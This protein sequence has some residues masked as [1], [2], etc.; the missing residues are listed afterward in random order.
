V[1]ARDKHYLTLQ[2]SQY[3][4]TKY[5]S[6]F[7]SFFEEIMTRAYSGFEKI[8]SGGGDGGNDGW[9]K[10]RGRYYQVYAP[11]TPSTKDSDAAKKLKADFNK[12]Q[13][14]WAHIAEVKEY[15]FVFN[16]RYQGA[17]KPAMAIAELEAEYPDVE[18]KLILASDLKET[19]FGLEDADMLGL[20][21]SIDQRDAVGVAYSYLEIAR[22]ELDREGPE[23]AK[24]ILEMGKDTIIALKDEDL[25]L[26]FEIL[27][28][29]CFQKMEQIDEAERGFE[30]LAKRVPADPRPLLYLSELNLNMLE[31]EDNSSNLEKARSIDADYWLLRLEELVRDIHLGVKPNAEGFDEDELPDESR[32]RSQFYRIYAL[33]CLL[34]ENE[35][36]ADVFIE[37]AIHSNG[38][39]LANFVVKL[40]I[41]ERRLT[42][43]SND[44]EM[45]AR[46]QSLLSDIEKVEE[47]FLAYGGICARYRA[48]LHHKKLTALRT[49]ENAPMFV[50][51][52]KETFDLLLSCSLDRQLEP[53][54]VDLLRSVGLPSDELVR[55]TDYLL[56]ERTVKS[57]ELLN[58]VLAQ[59]N[60]HDSLYT[61]GRE[62]FGEVG[63]ARY[64]ELIDA[65]ETKNHSRVLEI[66]ADDARLALTIAST[67][68]TDASLRKAIVSALPDDRELQKNKLLLLVN[69]DDNDFDEAF[70]ILKELDLSSLGAFE[71]RPILE[72][73]RKKEAWEFSVV[74]LQKLL[75]KETDNKERSKQELQLCEAFFE[76]KK[77]PDAIELGERLLGD[78]SAESVLGG[79][80]REIL[81][82]N[83]ILAC[84]ERAKIDDDAALR[85]KLILQSHQI[86]N[87]TF[88]FRLGIEAE[89]Y[90]LNNEP[91]NALASVVEAVKKKGTLSKIE[92]AKLFHLLSTRIGNAIDFDLSSL[93]VVQKGSFVKFEDRVQWSFVGDGSELDAIPIRE[94]NVRYKQLIGMNRGDSVVFDSGYGSE[95]REEK[96]EL[97]FSIEQ[98]IFWQ[99][100]DSFKSLTSGGDLDGVRAI[101]VVGED[102]TVDLE[103]LKQMFED[104][105]KRTSPLFDVYCRNNVPLAMLAASE[106]SLV[107]AIGKLQ[108]ESKGFVNFSSNLEEFG[109]QKDVAIS[110]L[111]EERP[112]Y[113]DGTS[114]VV[115]VESGRMTELYPLLPNLK[116]PQS[117]IGLL[118][119]IAGRFI[120]APGQ[121]GSMGYAN[122]RVIVSNLEQEKR[123]SIRSEF[124]AGVKLLEADPTKIDDISTA[125]KADCFSETEI[126]ASLCDACILSQDAGVPVLTEDRLY[127]QMNEMETKKTAPEYFS[128][129]A[130]VRVLYERGQISFDKYLTYLGYLSSY[131]FRFLSISSEDIEKA[132]FGDSTINVF[133]PGNI[134]RFNFPVILSEEYGVSFQDAYRVLGSFLLNVL[135]DSSIVAE[136][137]EKI[138]VELIESFP[139]SWNKA[140]V[141]RMML[142]DCRKTAEKM[143]SATII[144]SE[145]ERINETVKNLGRICELYA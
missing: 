58:Q 114:A 103:N 105:R 134:A 66:V 26:E 110:V 44:D 106:G 73:L 16:D 67:L 17:N 94:T 72:I 32:Q 28:C 46:S 86:A 85:A 116:V 57:D 113:I 132:V 141:G 140:D 37:K 88:E 129:F 97:V 45:L 137:A 35:D 144:S 115:L 138:F 50:Q 76:L 95:L 124:T 112:F 139:S 40:S 13:R 65:I 107:N 75:E 68:K 60:H 21:F 10:K 47:Q 99:S 101:K 4:H 25:A 136:Y 91:E 69:Y 1:N 98:Y 122:G 52:A 64:T 53:I 104:M 41:D 119:E 39:R 43:C 79:G 15:Y 81:I 111:D 82:A 133:S 61:D 108:H 93:D 62:F 22:T 128:S 109:R 23:R 143:S 38:E 120:Y 131:R 80:N 130:L 31:L 92:Y 118:T 24:T 3:I 135:R 84:F 127:L 54:L 125:N 63:D 59:F 102:D 100:V 36:Q 126:E 8:P 49:Q 11:D 7:Q 77:Y 34:S 89:T 78:S 71:S 145:M 18:F 142:S 14:N 51:V 96:I 33:I 83:T 117:V 90:L 19:F 27:E 5:G 48:I 55:L 9:I 12:L 123:D 87:P 6:E 121:M 56:S 29:L 20:G 42:K 30:S 74:V 2:F 70:D